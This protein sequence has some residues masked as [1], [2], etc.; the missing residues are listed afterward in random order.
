LP[1]WKTRGWKTSQNKPIANKDLVEQLDYNM[2]QRPIRFR[3]VKAHTN[4]KDWESTHNDM[5]D[6]LARNVV[7]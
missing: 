5:A 3:F 2:S 6:K 1:V 7:T 4:K